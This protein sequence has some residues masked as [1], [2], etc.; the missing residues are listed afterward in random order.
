MSLMSVPQ[1]LQHLDSK[2]DYTLLLFQVIWRSVWILSIQCTLITQH[3]RWALFIKMCCTKPLC[4]PL[5]HSAPCTHTFT[6]S[7]IPRRNV[8]PPVLLS[9]MFSGCGR[10]LERTQRKSTWGE[11]AQKIHTDRNPSSGL[12]RC[13]ILD[14]G[15]LLK[16]WLNV[17]ILLSK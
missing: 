13:R 7:F 8:V 3:L 5:L 4:L 2:S 17:W 9:S 1:P 10:K 11:Y 15:L 6:Y 16:K 14:A 12:N